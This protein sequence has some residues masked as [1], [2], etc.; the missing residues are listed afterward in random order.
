M[1]LIWINLIRNIVWTENDETRGRDIANAIP[2]INTSITIV[3]LFDEFSFLFLH[4]SFFSFDVIFLWQ[5]KKQNIYRIASL[6]IQKNI[7]I[8]TTHSNRLYYLDYAKNWHCTVIC[9]K[10]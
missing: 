8:Y 1:Q 3:H 6:P 7:N 2:F 10:I 4:F 9:K 5:N